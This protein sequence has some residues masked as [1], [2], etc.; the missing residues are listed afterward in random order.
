MVKVSHVTQGKEHNC[1]V[2]Y[3]LMCDPSVRLFSNTMLMPWVDS[4]EAPP[5]ASIK[6][7]FELATR[8]SLG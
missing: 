5:L 3:C 7:H 6:K 8:T 1:A 4:D 2:A